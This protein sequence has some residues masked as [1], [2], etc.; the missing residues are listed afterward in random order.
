MRQAADTPQTDLQGA[1]RLSSS[2]TG[3][4]APRKH[5]LFICVHVYTYV[6]THT[7]A[8]LHMHV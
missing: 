6:C 1:G 5:L 8:W 2:G 3:A 4:K 7:Q